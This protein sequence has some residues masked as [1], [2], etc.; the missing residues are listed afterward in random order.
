MTT[1]HK[2]KRRIVQGCPLILRDVRT[3]LDTLSTSLS[4][5]LVGTRTVL[6]TFAHCRFWKPCQELVSDYSWGKLPE[7]IVTAK[8][9]A[10]PRI[11]PASVV[12]EVS[13]NAPHGLNL[14]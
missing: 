5:S 9:V 14:P 6:F 3:T 12:D 7:W 13:A 10:M 8:A 1:G 4:L 2:Q 11:A